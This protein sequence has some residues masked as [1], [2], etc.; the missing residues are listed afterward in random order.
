MTCPS[1]RC[2]MVWLV[3][4]LQKKTYLGSHVWRYTSAGCMSIQASHDQ[5][6]MC[7]AHKPCSMVLDACPIPVQPAHK[8]ATMHVGIPL[9]LSTCSWHP[10]MSIQSPVS[11]HCT[12]DNA[13]VSSMPCRSCLVTKLEKRILMDT[14]T[15]CRTR[16]QTGSLRCQASQWEPLYPGAARGTLQDKIST[17][18]PLAAEGRQL[19]QHGFQRWRICH[20]RQALFHLTRQQNSHPG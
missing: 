20:E 10:L 8:W 19:H 18:M 14:I 17:D 4:L 3:Q 7:N 2:A 12:H 9:T 13:A 11:W 15:P 6:H 16:Q 5:E 1:N